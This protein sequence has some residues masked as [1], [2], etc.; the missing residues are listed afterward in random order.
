MEFKFKTSWFSK[1]TIFYIH[2]YQNYARNLKNHSPNQ[3]PNK[4]K[5]RLEDLYIVPVEQ[6]RGGLE[7]VV[8]PPMTVSL[9]NSSEYFCD[10]GYLKNKIHSLRYKKRVDPTQR[11]L[12]NQEELGFGSKW[13]F[14]WGAATCHHIQRWLIG[15][16]SQVSLIKEVTLFTVRKNLMRLDI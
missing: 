4:K 3:P 13:C 1:H 9:Q 12:L 8:S 6:L 11:S 16:K 14:C 10:F 15:F 7:S 5:N 2:T